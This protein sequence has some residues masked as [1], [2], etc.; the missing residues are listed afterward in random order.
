MPFCADGSR[1]RRPDADIARYA[2][3]VD[4]KVSRALERVSAPERQRLLRAILALGRDPLPDGDHRKKLAGVRPPL[5]RLREGPWRVLYRIGR[6]S[7]DVIDLIRRKDLELW[8][9]RYRR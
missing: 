8:L 1:R 5:Y 6:D 7:V 4:G 9:R 2:L 3:R